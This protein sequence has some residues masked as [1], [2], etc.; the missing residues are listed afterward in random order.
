MGLNVL[1]AQSL[2]IA[3]AKRM[4]WTPFRVVRG[5]LHTP[6]RCAVRRSRDANGDATRDGMSL[7]QT[8][9]RRIEDYILAT[10]AMPQDAAADDAPSRALLLVD[11]ILTS[12][13][14]IEG[15]TLSHVY[16]EQLSRC[17]NS[18]ALITTHFPT[19]AQP[20]LRRPARRH[21]PD[22]F[23]RWQVQQKTHALSTGVFVGPSAI[24]LLRH[25]SRIL[26]HDVLD[27]ATHD[28]HACLAA[29]AGAME[30]PV[31]AEADS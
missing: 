4:R 6:D 31:D 28:Y 5:Y 8:Q 3:R 14:P 27:K 19:L 15:A 20:A 22:H 13:N 18:L 21:A 26:E 25:E 29:D 7:F 2:G 16:A 30:E 10:R 1:L 17:A 23:A 11:E 12:T 9:V 24:E